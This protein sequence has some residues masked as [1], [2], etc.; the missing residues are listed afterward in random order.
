MA[1]E[2]NSQI[3]RSFKIFGNCFNYDTCKQ[4]HEKANPFDFFTDSYNGFQEDGSFIPQNSFQI[5]GEEKKEEG[6]VVMNESSQQ[7]IDME[8]HYQEDDKFSIYIPE[9]KSCDCCQGHVYNCQNLMGFCGDQ[10][11]CYFN[12]NKQK[13]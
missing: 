10:C 5:F 8:D 7:E 12:F 1:T 9:L 6:K 3:C 11:F 13:E 2:E 4:K